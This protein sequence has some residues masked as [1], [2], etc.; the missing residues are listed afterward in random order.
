VVLLPCLSK[1]GTFRSFQRYLRKVTYKV[2]KKNR[3]FLVVS[4]KEENRSV[5]DW[6][7]AFPKHCLGYLC[8]SVKSHQHLVDWDLKR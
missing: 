1:K 2:M 5:Y 8:G 3:V 4:K 6:C 7:K